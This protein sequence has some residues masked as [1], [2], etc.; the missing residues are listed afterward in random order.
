MNLYLYLASQCNHLSALFKSIIYQLMKK[1]KVQNTKHSDY[2][3]YTKYL[4][5]RQLVESER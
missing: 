5:R 1:Y 2:I 4:Y 3:R